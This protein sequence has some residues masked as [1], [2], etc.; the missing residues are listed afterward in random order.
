MGDAPANKAETADEIQV[1]QTGEIVVGDI[2]RRNGGARPPGIV[3][4]NV[5][6]AEMLDCAAD[7]IIEVGRPDSSPTLEFHKRTNA[8][9]CKEKKKPMEEKKL[10]VLCMEEAF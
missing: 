3:D 6:S 1:Q 7:Q 2:Q 5:E 8:F 10:Y 4:Q 9:N